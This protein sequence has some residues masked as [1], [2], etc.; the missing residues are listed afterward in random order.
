[1][2]T[3]R[4][5]EY[6]SAVNQATEALEANPQAAFLRAARGPSLNLNKWAKVRV[7]ISYRTYWLGK[8]LA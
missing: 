3:L 4:G 7:I 5:G 2:R 8:I 6:R 1:M